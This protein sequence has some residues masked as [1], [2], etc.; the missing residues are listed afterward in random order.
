MEAPRHTS[1]PCFSLQAA[2]PNILVEKGAR[3]WISFRK[4]EIVPTEALN[5]IASHYTIS[6][7]SMQEA[8]VEDTIKDI[9]EKRKAYTDCFF[10]QHASKHH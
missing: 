6:D 9:Y 5:L 3:R 10:F 4:E 1:C 2:Y 7:F 8:D